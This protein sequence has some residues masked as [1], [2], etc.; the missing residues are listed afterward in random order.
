MDHTSH[1]RYPSQTIP[2]R[3]PRMN[4]LLILPVLL[5]TLVLGTPAFSA[6]FQ[7]CVVRDVVVT[8]LRNPALSA[9]FQKGAAAFDSGD[10][11]TALR[12]WTPLAEQGNADAQSH[13][14]LMYAEG[15]GLSQIDSEQVLGFWIKKGEI[16]TGPYPEWVTQ[17]AAP[18]CLLQLTTS[19]N[20]DDLYSEINTSLTYSVQERKGGGGRGCFDSNVA[21]GYKLKIEKNSGLIESTGTY[22][23]A[24]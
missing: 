10:Y 8:P 11:T 22:L 12:E 4:R 20:G 14:G 7:R 24:S 2:A 19:L 5:L 15:Q 23:G 17:N 3:L 18:F 13:L 16:Y 6:D 9:D 1:I 21:S